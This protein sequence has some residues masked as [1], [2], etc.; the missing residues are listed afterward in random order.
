M[1]CSHPSLCPALQAHPLPSGLKVSCVQ[2][3]LPGKLSPLPGSLIPTHSWPLRSQVKFIWCPRLAQTPC[4]KVISALT[5]A[6]IRKAHLPHFSSRSSEFY[7][8]SSLSILGAK[9]PFLK[10]KTENK[11][12]NCRGLTRLP[13]LE[14][15]AFQSQMN[16]FL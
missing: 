6:I 3:P 8:F 5:W 2:F 13:L 12:L 9:A 4:H 15:V 11:D 10:K 7:L 14:A 1:I 16:E